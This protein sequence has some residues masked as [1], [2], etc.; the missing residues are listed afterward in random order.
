VKTDSLGATITKNNICAPY[1]M[2]KAAVPH[3]VPGSAIIATTSEQAFD[4][5]PELY[6]YAQQGGDDELREV[7]GEDARAKRYPC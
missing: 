6:A 3:L 7:A 2:I 4:P 1:W 5:I